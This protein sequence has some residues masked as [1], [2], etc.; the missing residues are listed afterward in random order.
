MVKSQCVVYEGVKT[1]DT[2]ADVNAEAVF[3]DFSENT[4]VVNRLLSRRKGVLAVDVELF[5]FS[6][7]KIFFRL[8]ALYSACDM[9]F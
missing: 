2:R 7:F 1:A 5:G 4:A 3:V 9:Y 8:K 6:L